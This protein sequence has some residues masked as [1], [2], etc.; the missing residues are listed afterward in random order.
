MDTAFLGMRGTG[1]WSDADTR[2]KDW[3]STVLYLYP[4]GD[5]PL[6]AL[7]ATMKSEK[8]TDPEYYWFTKGLPTQGGAVTGIYTDALSTAYVNGGSTG[9][10]VYLKMAADTANHFRAGHIV[11]MRDSSD[12]TVDIV[13]RVTANP[14]VNG[15]NSYIIVKLMEDD[16]NSSSHDLSDCDAVLI[17]GNS[18][19]EGAGMPSEIQYDPVKYYGKTQ[20]FRN[21]LAI[22]RTARKTKLRTYDQYKEAK[23]ECLQ[24][25]AMEMEK[26]FLWSI[27]TEGVGE[28]GKPERT[29]KG[30]I[31]WIRE[32]ADD[33]ATVADYTLDD[34]YAIEAGIGGKTWLEGA[35][36]WLNN[37]CEHIFRYGSDERMAFVGSG[38]ILAI[39]KVVLNYPQAR[40]EINTKTGAFG[41]KVTEWV[42]PF[43]II[44]LKRHPL[45]SY[46]ATTRNM[47][48]VFDPKDVIFKYIDDTTF[49]GQNEKTVSTAGERIDGTKE[50]Y[51][52]EAGLEFH[53]PAKCAFLTGFGQNN[54]A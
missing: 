28:N 11:L 1:D 52:T 41:I 13:G 17:I 15:A 45:F 22:T 8:A 43:G 33:G 26:A 25:H 7:T 19:P 9:D 2:P 14:T 46:D 18:N 24:L 50:E 44:Y 54:A 5:T 16:D 12:H 27:M 20:I 32:A 29:T 49:F 42:T 37:I 3:R 35:M 53:H 34:A 47:A 40:F 4:N 48:V 51:L 39:N 38:V 23:R 21:S 36:D 30:M 10:N 6:T 31:P